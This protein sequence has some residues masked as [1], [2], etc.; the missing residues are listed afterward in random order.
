M[1]NSYANMAS[2]H[3]S[4]ALLMISIIP[5]FTS[6]HEFMIS[7]CATPFPLYYE[8]ITTASVGYPLTHTQLMR[9][10]TGIVAMHLSFIPEKITMNKFLVAFPDTFSECR[11]FDKTYLSTVKPYKFEVMLQYR[12]LHYITPLASAEHVIEIIQRNYTSCHPYL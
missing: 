9:S 4:Q 1:R 12:M 10:M 7:T 5:K 11:P 8:H 3:V 2:K 6:T